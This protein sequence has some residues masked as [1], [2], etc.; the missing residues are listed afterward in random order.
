MSLGKRTHPWR[1]QPNKRTRKDIPDPFGFDLTPFLDLVDEDRSFGEV[2]HELKNFITGFGDEGDAK[3][4]EPKKVWKTRTQSGLFVTFGNSPQQVFKSG[5]HTK[6]TESIFRMAHSVLKELKNQE[7]ASIGTRA[8]FDFKQVDISR[9]NSQNRHKGENVVYLKAIHKGEWVVLKTTTDPMT[10][11][12]YVVDAI[13]HHQVNR[14]ASNYLTKLH[15]VAFSGPALVVCSGQMSEISVCDYINNIRRMTPRPDIA[16]YHMVE[17][18]CLAIRHLQKNSQFT[19]RDCHTANVYYNP[20]NRRTRFIDFDWSAVRWRN[21]VISVPRYLY[22]TTREQYGRNRSVDCCVFFR[23]LGHSLKTC[24]VFKE[25]IFDPIMQ[26]YELDCKEIL[27]RKM[28][29]GEQAARQ[30]YKMCTERGDTH[31]TFGHRYAL[32]RNKDFDYILG[33]Y[34]YSSMTPDTILQFLRANKFF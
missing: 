13:I 14:T 5:M 30:L 17:S 32:Q 25:K 20:K 11:L 33:Y 6:H 27:K 18:F 9:S 24:P 7:P 3:Y 31:T 8:S 34:T 23:T 19:H 12:R 28:E 29:A 10:Q 1:G 22:D 16:A 15:F 4:K 21:K 2:S 26:R